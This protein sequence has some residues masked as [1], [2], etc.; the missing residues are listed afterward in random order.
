MRNGPKPARL[1]P[2]PIRRLRKYLRRAA[3]RRTGSISILPEQLRSSYKEVA[4]VFVVRR[5]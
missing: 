1:R 5:D 2:F 3:A 4:I